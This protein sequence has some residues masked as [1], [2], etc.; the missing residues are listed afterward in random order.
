[1]HQ[2]DTHL[3]IYVNSLIVPDVC[4]SNHPKQS[5]FL[6]E[7]AVGKKAKLDVEKSEKN[8]EK[9]AEKTTIAR[10]LRPMLR[11][12]PFI[13][14]IYMTYEIPM[15]IYNMN[16]YHISKN[17]CCDSEGSAGRPQAECW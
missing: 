16:S 3:P 12:G 6:E 10:A 17:S 14:D 9:T 7:E 8:N 13:Y 4:C 5:G 2:K 1:M 15:P 11:S